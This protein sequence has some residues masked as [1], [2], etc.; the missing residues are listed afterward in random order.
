[1]CL[2]DRTVHKVTYN[3]IHRSFCFEKNKNSVRFTAKT[4]D[5]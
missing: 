4:K 1:M 5:T 3:S 2:F